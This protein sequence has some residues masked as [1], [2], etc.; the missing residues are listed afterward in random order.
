MAYNQVAEQDFER[1][2]IRGFWRKIVARLT[3]ANNKLLPFDEIRQRLPVRGQ[4]YL[5]IRQVEVDNIIGSLGR[6]H[7]FDR[8]FLPTQSRTR[9]RWL[10]IDKAHYEDVNLP[11]VELF[12][13]GEVYFVKDGNH[14]ISVARERGQIFIDAYIIEIDTPVT[15]TPDITYDQLA[16]KAE[17]AAFMEATHLAELRPDAKIETTLPGLYTRLQEQIS[18]HRWFI[19]ER[20]STEV[21]PDEAVTAWYDDIY[22]PVVQEIRE[23]GLLKSFPGSTEADLYLWISEYQ[24]YL[25]EA[26]KVGGRDG[27][28]SEV[29]GAREEAASQLKV[30]YP[31]R[32]VKRLV[33][34]LNRTDWLGKLIMDQ[35]RAA[36][37]EKTHLD[38][39]RPQVQLETT[40]PGKYDIL[41]EHIAVHRWFLGEQ[42]KAEVP[43]IEAAESWCDNVYEPLVDVIREQGI[44]R[45]FPGRTVTDLYLWVVERR[46]YLRQVYGSDV[47]VE[48]AVEQLGDQPP[49]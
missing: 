39:L 41:L 31:L 43:Y 16:L 47:P 15:L 9:D 1:A 42:R 35:D 6:Y 3:G 44:L 10:S 23:Q 5:G 45:Q 17:Q 19:G 21:T 34:V 36:F 46:E 26:I 48:Q 8:A 27:Q 29:L 18:L 20:R 30:D 14:R 11:P 2:V 7:D 33:N 4:H 37:F 13:I 28:A 49:D 24:S 12:K 25:R 32:S 22:L 40:L 38:Q